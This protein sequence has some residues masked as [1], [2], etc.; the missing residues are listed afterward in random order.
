MK[1]VREILGNLD[2]SGLWQPWNVMQFVNLFITL[3]LPF[4]F[5]SYWFQI[6]VGYHKWCN[7]TVKPFSQFNQLACFLTYWHGKAPSIGHI[8]M[9]R[10]DSFWNWP[11]PQK[12][13]LF[14]VQQQ[15]AGKKTNRCG[16]ISLCSWKRQC[17]LTQERIIVKV[18]IE[19]AHRKEWGG[20]LESEDC[21]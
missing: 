15:P 7:I 18:Y 2:I 20:G 8:H 21:Q 16:Q 10:A 19:R 4:G 5:G 14:S 6:R 17:T 9:L 1:F 13:D 11:L 3:V 12:A